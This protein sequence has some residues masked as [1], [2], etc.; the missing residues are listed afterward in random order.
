MQIY[1]RVSWCWQIPVQSCNM[2]SENSNLMRFIFRL[3]FILSDLPPCEYPN[4]A[5]HHFWCL[6]CIFK[7]LCNF[8]SNHGALS[9]ISGQRCGCCSHGWGLSSIRIFLFIKLMSRRFCRMFYD[10]CI[11]QTQLILLLIQWRHTKQ[12]LRQT[13]HPKVDKHDKH[14]KPSEVVEVQPQVKSRTSPRADNKGK[15]PK[16]TQ[17]DGPVPYAH[18]DK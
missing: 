6:N 1:C 7:S 14:S 18:V 5:F 15:E 16:S 3:I 13:S 10:E 17:Y 11:F 2:V 9:F 12:N 8:V 4:V